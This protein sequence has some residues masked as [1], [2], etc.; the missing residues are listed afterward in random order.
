MLNLS[1]EENDNLGQLLVSIQNDISRHDSDIISTKLAELGIDPHA[2]LLVES[3]KRQ[4]PTIEYQLRELNGVDDE[5]FEDKFTK[6]MKYA[7][8]DRRSNPEM[9]RRD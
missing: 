3:M 6:I 7:W 4:A 2:T 8:I 5:S 1:E 9:L